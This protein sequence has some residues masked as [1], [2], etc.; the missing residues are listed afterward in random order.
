MRYA[1]LAVLLV[2]ALAAPS[3]GDERFL[4]GVHHDRAYRLY[5]PDAIA[6]AQPLIVALHGCAQT[7]ED[8]ALGTRLN[9]AAARRGLG[10]LYPAQSVFANPARCWNWFDF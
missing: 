8:F 6:P 10:V 9:R 4:R 3:A 2:L 7:P 5:V 1:T